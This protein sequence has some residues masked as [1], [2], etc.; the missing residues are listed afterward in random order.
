MC[1][2]LSFV[3]SRLALSELNV[4]STSLSRR[5]IIWTFEFTRVRARR[6]A[7][8]NDRRAVRSP[9]FSFRW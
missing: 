6:R 8:P 9:R 2:V 3:F 7:A 1:V 5:I 4:P